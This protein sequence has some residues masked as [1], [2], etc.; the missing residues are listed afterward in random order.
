MVEHR[1]NL[2]TG[3]GSW[4]FNDGVY[5]YPFGNTDVAKAMASFASMEF[6]SKG[7]V[8]GLS[9]ELTTEWELDGFDTI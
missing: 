5:F 2:K 1:K 3:T 9:G 4:G 8:D 7:T 6:R